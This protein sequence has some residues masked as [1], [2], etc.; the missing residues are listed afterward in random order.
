MKVRLTRK[1]TAPRN[2]AARA[3]TSGRF[4]PKVEQA[5]K[6]YRRKGRYAPDPL[7]D[8]ERDR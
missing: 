6:T 8:A 2:L 7:G 3:L 5:P 4:K 1:Q